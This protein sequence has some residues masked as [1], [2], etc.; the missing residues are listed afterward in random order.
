MSFRGRGGGFNRGGGGG[1]GGGGRGGGFG[2]GG[3]GGGNAFKKVFI[4]FNSIAA[5]FLACNF[6]LNVFPFNSFL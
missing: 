1:R 4:S 3:G 5:L 2:R 6:R